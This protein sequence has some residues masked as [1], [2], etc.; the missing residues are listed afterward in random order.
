MIKNYKLFESVGR[1]RRLRLNDIYYHGWG[2]DNSDEE[3]DLWNEFGFGY[4]DY[5]AMWVTEEEQIAEEFSDW[6]GADIRVV[7][8]VQVKTTGIAEIDYPK[9]QD[10]MEY[11]GLEDFREIIDILKR[12]DYKG[13]STPGA[14]GSNKYDDVALFYPDEQIKI[15]EAKVSIDEG[16]WTNYMKLED[17]TE[18]LNKNVIA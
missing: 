17:A 8:K 5:E 7:Y 4:S 3:I 15:L 14:I 18:Y 2:M 10:L 6:R 12:Y 1:L 11:W 13:W 9:S 16:D